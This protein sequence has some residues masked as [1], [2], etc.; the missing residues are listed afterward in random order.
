MLVSFYEPATKT[1]LNNT[2]FSAVSR[3]TCDYI[4]C[5]DPRNE[6][7]LSTNFKKLLETIDDIKFPHLGAHTLSTLKMVVINSL[8]S[9][10]HMEP[11]HLMMVT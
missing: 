9:M 3:F 5:S 4:H 6:D 1:S 2:F 8:F 7:S 11:L 10:L